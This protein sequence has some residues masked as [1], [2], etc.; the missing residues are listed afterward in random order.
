MPQSYHG[1]LKN[2]YFS[3]QK[4]FATGPTCIII[5]KTTFL[6]IK[7]NFCEATIEIIL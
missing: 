3:N 5:R 4:P 6:A 7:Q 1:K 2:V